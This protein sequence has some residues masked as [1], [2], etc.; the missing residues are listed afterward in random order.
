MMKLRASTIRR[1]KT[2]V[3]VLLI[4]LVLLLCVIVV[5][6]IPFSNAALKSKVERLLEESIN[7][8]CSIDGLKIT[9]WTGISATNVKYRSHDGNRAS[10]VFP[11]IGVSYFLLPLIFK[12][13][14]IKNISVEKPELRFDLPPT[15]SRGKKTTEIFSLSAIT[16][17]L[18][19]VP[20]TIF[21]RNISILDA[22]AIVVSHSKTIAEGKAISIFMKVGLKRELTLDGRISVA[23]IALSGNL[24][25]SQCKSSFRLRGMNVFLD[26]FRSVCYGGSLSARGAADLSEGMLNSL[27]IALRDAKLNEWNPAPKKADGTVNGKLDVSIDFDKSALGLDSL[28]GK[29]RL[30][31]TDVVAQ[32]T[33]LQKSLVLLLFIPKL[34]TLSFSKIHTDLSLAKGKI[35]TGNFYGKGDPMDFTADGWIDLKENFSERIEGTFSADFSRNLPPLIKN[36]LL[37]VKGDDD[38]RLFQCTAW[39]TFDNP[40]LKVDQ[41]IVDRAIGNVFDEI[42]K[43]LENLFRKK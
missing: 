17:V 7:G 1:R 35:H 31:A 40:K 30:T 9:A 16:R 19:T 22:H 26:D 41:K 3:V 20:Y 43:G 23:E 32:G 6:F 38:K 2:F 42:G 36:S 14:I 5:G 8:D 29:G 27:T 4:C 15:D 21:V 10:C 12:Q 11:R 18:A 37:P 24:R 13:L 25:V 28:K 33:S 39:G 34:A